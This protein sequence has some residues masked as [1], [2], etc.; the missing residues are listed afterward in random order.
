MI[1]SPC[2]AHPFSQA[3]VAPQI[4]RRQAEVPPQIERRESDHFFSSLV[5]LIVVFQD[6]VQRIRSVWQKLAAQLA[7]KLSSALAEAC[8]CLYCWLHNSGELRQFFP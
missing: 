1:A 3:E 5:E 4:E 6:C 7:V 2:L 8:A